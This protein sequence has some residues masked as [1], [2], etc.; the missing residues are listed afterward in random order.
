MSN[1]FVNDKSTILKLWRDLRN[2]LSSDKSDHDHLELTVDFWSF[3]PIQ[4]RILD[5]DNP[6]NWPDP[7]QLIHNC[8]YDESC[9]ALG[10][11]HTLWLTTDER[12]QNNRLELKLIKD[13]ERA[14]QQIILV[15]DNTYKLN[16]DYRKINSDKEKY[17]IQETYEFDGK[18]H[19]I[20][21]LKF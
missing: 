21:T 4:S 9:I 17:F 3:A 1:P 12:W 7:W 10:M 2:S 8:Q 5:W 20:K 19:R 16:L 14:L 11:F 15:V 13:P 6:K 18:I